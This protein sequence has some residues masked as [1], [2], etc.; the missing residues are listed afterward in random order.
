MTSR[1]YCAHCAHYTSTRLK[2]TT[3]W[4]SSVVMD[5]QC[6]FRS[7]S[8]LQPSALAP[9][10]PSLTSRYSGERARVYA[11]PPHWQGYDAGY[12]SLSPAGYRSRSVG[13]PSQ[14]GRD[15]R[16]SGFWA[17]ARRPRGPY[18]PPS[19]GGRALSAPQFLITLGRGRS[20]PAESSGLTAVVDLLH[21]VF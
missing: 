11:P 10:S 14:R 8:D 20:W 7:S 18:L 9:A 15:H 19:G 12:Q 16:P 21:D 17:P 6:T 4:S 1:D 5:A 3:M 13:G 2:D